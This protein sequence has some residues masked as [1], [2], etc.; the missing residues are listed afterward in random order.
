MTPSLP[1]APGFRGWRIVWV[2]F[3]AQAFAVGFTI[4]PYGLFTP[5]IEREFET[6]TALSQLGLGFF[7]VVM[8][9]AGPVVGPLLDRH[10]I[11]GLMSAGAL[12]LS[13]SFLALSLATQLWQIG[14]LFGVLTAVGVTMLGPLAATTVVAKWFERRRGLAVGLAAMGV[15]AG[16]LVLVPLAGSLIE[17]L[18]WRAT[19]QIFAALNLL[20]VPFLWSTVRNRPEDVGQLPDGEPAL[21]SDA[22]APAGAGLMWSSAAILR[23]R[24]FWALALGVGIVFGF[25]GGW[26]ANVPKFGQDLGHSLA[27]MSQL[28]GIG[29]G[30]GIPGTLIFGALA[31]RFDNRRLLWVSIAVQIGALLVLRSQPG[32]TWLAGALFVFGLSAGGMLPVYASLIGRLFGPLSFGRVMGLAGL[33]MLPFGA[34]APVIAGALRDAAGDY[35]SALGLIALAFTGG[36]AILG[37]VSVTRPASP[38]AEKQ[39]SPGA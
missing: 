8:T 32:F 13:G 37:L 22:A 34:A 23:T 28:M 2:A 33:V 1:R 16:G 17:A 27:R 31:D 12:L 29:A 6:S 36:A 18:G 4:I 15:P 19:L 35:R 7:T 9:L 30:L 38:R 21:E 24:S 26:N 5:S 25:G 3:A 20:I 14:L 39:E 11:R 10:S